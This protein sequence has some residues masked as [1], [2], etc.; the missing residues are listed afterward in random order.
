MALGDAVSYDDLILR[1]PLL[2]S[3]SVTEHARRLGLDP[4]QVL[5]LIRIESA[6]RA[7]ARSPA[8]A[9]GLMQLMPDTARA[10]APA[11]GIT[12]KDPASLLDAASN[13]ALGTQ[14]LHA[15][16][17]RFH[18]N[19]AMAAAAYNAGPRR[20]WQWQTNGCV[21]AE[22]WIEMIPFS[23]TRGYVRRAIF[24]AAIYQWR[25]QRPIMKLDA[26]M[27]PIPPRDAT[28]S[29]ACAR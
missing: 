29:H 12:F 2:Y 20:V 25:L 13:V 26:V 7:D 16:I 23:E 24:T 15:M 17:E 8:G 28:D 27:T 21:A 5:A 22:R 10:T 4:A 11:A 1:F 6:F 18:G 3:N 19:F 14:Y 9:V